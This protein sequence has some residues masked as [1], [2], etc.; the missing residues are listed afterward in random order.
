MAMLTRLPG[1]LGRGLLWAVKNP[2]YALIAALAVYVLYLRGCALINLEQQV[3]AYKE[4]D[5]RLRE[6]L[7]RQ[8]EAVKTVQRE[9][10]ARTARSRQR[11][12]AVLDARLPA[13][14]G[15]DL[16]QCTDYYLQ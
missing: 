8:T 13:V 6:Q 10:Q 16:N 5:E 12:S 3:E 11:A 2:R 7:A 4:G 9:G 1:Y 15:Q 14:C